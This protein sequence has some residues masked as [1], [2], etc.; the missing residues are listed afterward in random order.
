M[1]TKSA[2]ANL[3]GVIGL[4]VRAND[5]QKLYFFNV[6]KNIY[7]AHFWDMGCKPNCTGLLDQFL[8]YIL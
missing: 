1:L 7:R 6:Y 4:D 2:C 8:E 3:A 5:L